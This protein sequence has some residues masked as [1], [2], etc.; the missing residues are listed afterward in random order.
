MGLSYVSVQGHLSMQG[1]LWW[2][3]ETLHFI[4]ETYHKPEKKKHR[5]EGESGRYRCDVL[6]RLI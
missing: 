4:L 1:R 5:P 3:E 2:N 6:D